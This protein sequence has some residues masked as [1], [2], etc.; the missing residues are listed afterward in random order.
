MSMRNK[1]IQYVIIFWVCAVVLF[2]ACN[3]KVVVPDRIQLLYGIVFIVVAGAINVL[4]YWFSST[5][6]Q[7]KCAILLGTIILSAVSGIMS[8]IGRVPLAPL[9]CVIICGS[10]TYELA[11]EVGGWRRSRGK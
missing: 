2:F 4:I 8:W 1:R 6:R 9:L 11:R 10:A 7:F 3:V 5:W